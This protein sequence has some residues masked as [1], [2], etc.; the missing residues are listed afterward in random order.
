MQGAQLLQKKRRV[1][2]PGQWLLQTCCKA[3]CRSSCQISVP[4]RRFTPLSSRLP[5]W[6]QEQVLAYLTHDTHPAEWWGGI[7]WAGGVVVLLLSTPPPSQPQ[8]SPLPN[9]IS[10]LFLP[11]LKPPLCPPPAS[12]SPAALITAGEVGELLPVGP[13]TITCSGPGAQNS[14]LHFATAPKDLTLPILPV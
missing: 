5:C 2:Q 13:L 6:Q 9:P 1:A 14:V 7:F 4:A 8:S 3:C 11:S 10:S 12:L